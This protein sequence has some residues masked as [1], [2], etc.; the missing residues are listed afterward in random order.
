VAEYSKLAIFSEG[1]VCALR[2][3]RRRLQ[4]EK[5]I[6]RKRTTDLLASIV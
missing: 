3:E 1:S 4:G 6:A 2:E 5:K